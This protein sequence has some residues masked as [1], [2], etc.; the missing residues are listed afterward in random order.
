MEQVVPCRVSNYS[1]TIFFFPLKRNLN[2]WRCSLARLQMYDSHEF[3]N[4]TATCNIM[5][6][7]D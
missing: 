5:Q 2:L 6:K 7:L 3:V 4:L 1:M